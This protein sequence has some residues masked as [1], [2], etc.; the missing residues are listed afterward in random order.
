M[1][2]PY[3]FAL[4]AGFVYALS[5]FF[6]KI[7]LRGAIGVVRLSFLMNLVF[8]LVFSLLFLGEREAFAW[9]LLHQ[10]VIA[11]I[12]FFIGQ[13]FTFSAIR[14][15][16]VSIQTPL[17]GT[18]VIFVVLLIFLVKGDSI[19]WG[20]VLAAVLSCFAVLLLGFSGKKQK[21]LYK[22]ILL[23]LASSFF[24]A[25]ADVFISLW[26]KNFGAKNFVFTTILVNGLLSFTLIPFFRGP[27]WDAAIFRSKWV[28]IS[29]FAMAGQAL[30][31]N[32]TLA[33]YQNAAV[34]NILYSSRGL[35]SVVLVAVL[36]KLVL[37]DNA[38]LSKG[39]TWQRLIGALLMSL[40]IFLVFRD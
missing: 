3:F 8:V 35:W 28:W 39:E 22:A 20:T 30:L 2:E 25:G 37:G 33:Y 12:C 10:P 14:V 9:E 13:V 5:A 23:V 36:G 34:T 40:S 17:M 19:A 1:S 6:T 29:C 15:G 38:T 16:D 27:I 21:N 18:K 24:F 4:L 7:A 32:Y 31:L 26:G 11:G